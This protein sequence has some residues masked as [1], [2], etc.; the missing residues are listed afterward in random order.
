MG[1]AMKII[2]RVALLF[3]VS[4]FITKANAAAN[5]F[6]V[7]GTGSFTAINISS[8]AS[9]TG[10]VPGTCAATS[11]IPMNTGDIATFDSASGGGTV[12]VTIDLINLQR[13]VCGTFG[14]TLDW[15]ANNKNV[16]LTASPSM[17]CSGSG[18]KTVNLGNGTWTLSDNSNNGTLWDASAG[19]GTLTLNANGSTIAYTGVGTGFLQFDGGGKTY[20][21]VTFSANS[22]GGAINVFSNN[23]FA[24]LN[25][26]APNSVFFPQG[27]T[28]TVTNAFNWVGTSTN[29]ILIAPGSVNSGVATI[30][31]ASGSTIQWSGLHNIIFTGT[32][33]TVTN[34]FNFGGNS[35]TITPPAIGGGG[36][37]IIGG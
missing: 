29:Q 30:V 13:I 33:P 7:G 22:S 25:I 28:Q 1:A 2:M 35:A 36:G 6:W 5:C 19:G 16:T 27:G 34:S 14:G 4:L 20:N 12:T 31:S 9:S 11:S 32:Q 24:T 8:W 10:G 18:T 3:L 15:S 21:T 26:G 17:G 37:K 23:T